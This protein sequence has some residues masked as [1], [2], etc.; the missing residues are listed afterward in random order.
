MGLCLLDYF[1]R[2]QQERGRDRQ[3]KGLGGLEVDH[4]LV[5]SRLFNRQVGGLG[6]PENLVDVS[7][8]LRAG[9]GPLAEST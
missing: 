4:Q 2:P 8:P 7:E 9:R 1:V 5:L 6:A 3:A